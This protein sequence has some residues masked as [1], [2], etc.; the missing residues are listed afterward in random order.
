MNGERK[1][2]RDYLLFIRRTAAPIVAII[3][4]SIP[5]GAV[6]LA[7]ATGA[8]TVVVSVVAGI[9]AVVVVGIA[10][11]LAENA[12]VFPSTATLWVQS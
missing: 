2:I 7:V 1:K 5:K 8:G 3:P 11:S 6:V 4:S 10:T 12:W 9:V